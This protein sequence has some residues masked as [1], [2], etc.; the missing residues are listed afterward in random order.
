MKTGKRKV[1][2]ITY[3][4]IDECKISEEPEEV[5]FYV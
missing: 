4:L 3:H 5:E 1:R 2:V